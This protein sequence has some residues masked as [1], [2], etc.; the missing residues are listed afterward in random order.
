MPRTNQLVDTPTHNDQPFIERQFDLFASSSSSSFI[1]YFS[2]SN[3]SQKVTDE[4]NKSQ[5]D[6][7]QWALNEMDTAVLGIYLVGYTRV[8]SFFSWFW[9]MAC[10]IHKKCGFISV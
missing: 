3:E 4:L 10:S 2:F 7:S 8:L 5:D 6:I 1:S 9:F